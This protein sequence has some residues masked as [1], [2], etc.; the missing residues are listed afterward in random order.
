[1]PLRWK[2]Q[3]NLRWLAFA[4]LVIALGL[5]WYR[6]HHQAEAE[7]ARLPGELAVLTTRSEDLDRRLMTN[8]RL[9]IRDNSL[10][11]LALRTDRWYALRN[12][13]RFSGTAE[14]YLDKLK[15]LYEKRQKDPFQ[16]QGESFSSFFAQIY[17]APVKEFDKAIGPFM[18][19]MHVPDASIAQEASHLIQVLL[20]QRGPQMQPHIP[21]LMPHLEQCLAFPADEVRLEAIQ[22][23][24]II[25]TAPPETLTTLRKIAQDDLDDLAVYAVLAL[26]ELDEKYP[27]ST[28]LMELVQRRI[29]GWEYAGEILV[30]VLPSSEAQPFFQRQY[31]EASDDRM[32]QYFAQFLN[33]VALKEEAEPREGEA[34]D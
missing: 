17:I 31:A 1:M 30:D 21:E 2:P 3:I 13:P 27:V 6:D 33:D 14:E 8:S 23:L 16:V 10:T 22:C 5:G 32:R 29:K 12:I 18:E 19:Y 11:Y 20:V 7:L 25:G 24:K 15:Q 4:V 9:P 34:D 28:R 26:R